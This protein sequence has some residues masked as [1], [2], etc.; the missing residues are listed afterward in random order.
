MIILNQFYHFL[1]KY[2]C[3]QILMSDNQLPLFWLR[4]RT[5]ILETFLRFYRF[6][7]SRPVMDSFLEI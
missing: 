6:R 3:H 4:E 5:T 7:N 1:L 2:E